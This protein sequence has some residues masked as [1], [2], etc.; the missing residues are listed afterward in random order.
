MVIV[1][2]ANVDLKGLEIDF[3]WQELLMLK[4]MFH[5]WMW[6]GFSRILS[7]PV[8]AHMHYQT[9]HT[10]F[11]RGCF[12]TRD[13][14]K[15]RA[16]YTI[17]PRFFFEEAFR[18]NCTSCGLDSRLRAIARNNRILHGIT[19]FFLRV[20]ILQRSHIFDLNKT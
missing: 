9:H 16:T 1:P 8:H 6:I 4:I 3:Q 17:R 12:C 5:L 15:T 14:Q 13:A 11:R 10:Q 2:R 7:F 20:F 18:R 19:G